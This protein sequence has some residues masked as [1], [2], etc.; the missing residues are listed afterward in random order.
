MATGVKELKL[1]QEAVALA[2]EVV[3][4]VRQLGRRETKTFTDRLMHTAV[5][6]A[7]AVADGYGRYESGEQRRLY[8][9]ARRSLAEL[10][11]HLAVARHAGI[12]PP[13]TLAQLS[14]RISTVARLLSGY[15]SYIDRQL[16]A[17]HRAS[18][19][20]GACDEPAAVTVAAAGGAP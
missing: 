20:D 3:R 8:L 2:G 16:A 17:E 12:I 10:E 18:R 9:S 15:L 19:V 4:L 13:P 5:A 11:T 7:A 6:V 1:W 14:G